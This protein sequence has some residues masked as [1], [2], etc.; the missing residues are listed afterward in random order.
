MGRRGVGVRAESMG[1]GV[2]QPRRVAGCSP[3]GPDKPNG[4][5]GNRNGRKRRLPCNRADK[6]CVA[7]WGQ[8]YLTAN[9]AELTSRSRSTRDQVAIRTSG[10]TPGELHVSRPR[11]VLGSRCVLN[12]KLQ[13]DVARA[14]TQKMALVTEILACG[15]RVH[16]YPHTSGGER[17]GAYSRG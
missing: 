6:G 1:G 11:P 4:H 12:L 3:I 10:P 16:S 7:S 5:A 14:C 17:N 13:T 15:F 9:G 8:H 2:D